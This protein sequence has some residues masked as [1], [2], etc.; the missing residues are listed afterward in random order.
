MNYNYN[1]FQKIIII[2]RNKYSLERKTKI[3]NL[4]D[5]LY[6]LTQSVIQNDSG[7]L[8]IYHNLILNFIS[9][10]ISIYENIIFRELKELKC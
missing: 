4:Y 2:C 1:D 10:L 8:N 6:N 5:K 3:Y 9:D 7:L